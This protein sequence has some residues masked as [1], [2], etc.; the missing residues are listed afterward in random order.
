MLRASVRKRLSAGHIGVN[1]E[2]A[3]AQAGG[4]GFLEEDSGALAAREQ[5][6]VC[7]LDRKSLSPGGETELSCGRKRGEGLTDWK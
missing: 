4:G 3:P 7:K 6:E 2:Q 5:P 1:E